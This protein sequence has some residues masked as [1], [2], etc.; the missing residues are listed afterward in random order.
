MTTKKSI[1]ILYY[2]S[3]SGVEN[4]SIDNEKS[5][6]EFDE[7]KLICIIKYTQSN[8]NS[9]EIF[10]II[11]IQLLN[12]YNDNKLIPDLSEF[13][14][15]NS[16]KKIIDV[17]VRET[18]RLRYF[19]T[20]LYKI[21]SNSVLNCQNKNIKCFRRVLYASLVSKNDTPNIIILKKEFE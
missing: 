5:I 16:K 18:M 21:A 14:Y 20:K 13:V 9:D 6:V 2:V 11:N 17:H 4:G 1:T 3:L 12:K 8:M 7:N 10:N 15:Q 19:T